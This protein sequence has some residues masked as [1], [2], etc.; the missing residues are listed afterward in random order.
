MVSPC[1]HPGWTPA[2]S[3]AGEGAGR[4]PFWDLAAMFGSI[5]GG[6]QGQ[7][8]WGPRQPELGGGWPCPKQGLGLGGLWGPFQ[9][10][11]FCDS[12][13][14]GYTESSPALASLMEQRGKEDTAL[15]WAL[16]SLPT[17]AILWCNTL[18]CDVSWS[19]KPPSVV[20]TLASWLGCSW[21]TKT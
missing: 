2:A 20:T 17:Q 21:C 7:A 3:L 6:A 18:W 1:T 11:P 13:I 10:K 12:T 14:K 4:C 16:G 19:K 8:G 5:P 15:G 9:H